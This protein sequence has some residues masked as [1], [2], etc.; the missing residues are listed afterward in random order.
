MRRTRRAGMHHS[1]HESKPET[2]A[3][4]RPRRPCPCCRYCSISASKSCAVF[5]LGLCDCCAAGAPCILACWALARL[6]PFRIFPFGAMGALRGV[7]GWTRAGR[8]M[9]ALL[10]TGLRTSKHSQTDPGRNEDGGGHGARSTGL[11]VITYEIR[12]AQQDRLRFLP[13]ALLNSS[14]LAGR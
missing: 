14:V 11:G 4:R 10:V 3:Q 2:P 12:T 9:G 5:T 6:G 13:D 7:G 1:K 8:D